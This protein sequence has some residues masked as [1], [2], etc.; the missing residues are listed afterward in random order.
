M[1]SQLMKEQNAIKVSNFAL[2]QNVI[3]LL[4]NQIILYFVQS[5]AVK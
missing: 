5:C 4:L 1:L 2:N 3:V